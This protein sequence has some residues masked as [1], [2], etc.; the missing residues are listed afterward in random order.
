MKKTIFAIVALVA[1]V[2]SVLTVVVLRTYESHE[3]DIYNIKSEINYMMDAKDFYISAN[4]SMDEEARKKNFT[5]IDT[6]SRSAGDT[7][8]S[9]NA[10]YINGKRVSGHEYNEWVYKITDEYNNTIDEANDTITEQENRLNN[11]TLADWFNCKF[12]G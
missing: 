4:E 2:S 11:I 3:D 9:L 5:G 1:I 12:G 8:I 10:C 7:V 6:Y